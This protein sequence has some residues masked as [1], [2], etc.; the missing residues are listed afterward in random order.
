MVTTLNGLPRS[1]EYLI[2]GICARRRLAKFGRLW[3]ECTQEEAR[4]IS[5]EDNMGEDENQSLKTH[6]KK[7]KTKKEQHS[8]KK[9]RR[10]QKWDY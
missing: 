2:Q 7:K 5:I 8:H 1:W 6:A 10:S 4:L 3:E 9:T